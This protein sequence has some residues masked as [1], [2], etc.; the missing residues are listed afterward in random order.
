MVI[1]TPIHTSP[2]KGIVMMAMIQFTIW[3][4][5]EIHI[6]NGQYMINETVTS[7]QAI[8]LGN[9]WEERKWIKEN[10]NNLQSAKGPSMT[11][12][13]NFR[14]FATAKV[15]LR[16]S[17]KS[18]ACAEKINETKKS[19]DFSKMSSVNIQI[20][21]TL[22]D[23]DAVAQKSMLKLLTILGSIGHSYRSSW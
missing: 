16:L 11:L 21:R 20:G 14:L 9:G 19:M 13:N 3:L 17:S 7:M 18:H 6:M 5:N 4:Q 8:W 1:V 12:F 23:I 15:C 10:S 2:S 22:I